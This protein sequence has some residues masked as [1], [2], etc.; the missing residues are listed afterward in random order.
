MTTISQFDHNSPDFIANPYPVYAHL[1]EHDPVH[2]SENYGGYYVLTQYEDVRNALLDWQLF[3]SAR[4]GV[5]SIPTSVKRDFQEIPL[6]VDPP[7]HTPYRKLIS[8]FFTR[9]AIRELEPGFRDIAKELLTPM[10][11]KGINRL[12]RSS[13]LTTSRCP[14]FPECWPTSCRSPRKSRNGGS[15]GHRPFSMAGSRTGRG[16]TGRARR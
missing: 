12:R 4:P 10:A 11:A 15:S 1:Q 2:F 14:T 13:C 6:E 3:S 9:K 7:E 5:T 8:G 16:R